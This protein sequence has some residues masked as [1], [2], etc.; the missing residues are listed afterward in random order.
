VLTGVRIRWQ[1]FLHYCLRVPSVLAF[2]YQNA[3]AK[4]ESAY[5]RKNIGGAERRQFLRVLGIQGEPLARFLATSCRVTRSSIQK[6]HSAARSST[7]SRWAVR[8]S[9]GAKSK[10]SY[11]ASDRLRRYKEPHLHYT[12]F[13]PFCPYLIS[14]F[15]LHTVFTKKSDTKR[16]QISPRSCFVHNNM[17]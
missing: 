8:A 1:E 3:N 4:S 9:I 11:P 15:P 7:E 12:P 5:F 6:R 17:I 2:Y 13:S 14:V 10:A 16:P